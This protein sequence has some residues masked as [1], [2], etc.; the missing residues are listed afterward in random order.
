LKYFEDTSPLASWSWDSLSFSWEDKLPWCS[1]KRSFSFRKAESFF[2]N[3][4]GEANSVLSS[5]SKNASLYEKEKEKKRG[6]RKERKGKEKIE[7]R[8]KRVK[9][10]VK[11]KKEK[12]EFS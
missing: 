1:T 5:F 10:E 4:T 12:K 3:E 11:R 9:E 6:S 2:V 8:R 7:K